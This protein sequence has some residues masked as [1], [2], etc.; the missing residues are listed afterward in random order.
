MAD[1]LVINK[2]DGERLSLALDAKRDYQ[3]ALRL[4]P[5]KAEDWQPK[6]M[7]CSALLQQGVSEISQLLH[8]YHQN[9]ER[10]RER[11]SQ[12]NKYWFYEAIENGLRSRF[13]QD[14]AIQKALAEYEAAIAS[15]ALSPFPAAEMLLKLFAGR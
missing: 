7:T 11:R 13:F 9:E 3:T 12:Q 5:P 2:A 15:G 10:I 4:F 8:Q 6:V 14:P 1:L